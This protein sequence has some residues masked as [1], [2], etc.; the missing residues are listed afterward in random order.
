MASISFTRNRI[1][2]LGLALIF[3]V[4]IYII[5]FRVI[6]QRLERLNRRILKEVSLEKSEL[7][8]KEFD[9]FD[10]IFHLMGLAADEGQQEFMN[11]LIEQDSVKQ[12]LVAYS[13]WKSE[14][15]VYSKKL[16]WYADFLNIDSVIISNEL[17]DRHFSTHFIKSN[18]GMYVH[19]YL[20]TKSGILQVTLDLHKL[21]AYFWER[22]FGRHAYFELYDIDGVCLIYPDEKRIGQKKVTTWKRYPLK[23]STVMSDFVHM[24]VLMEEFKLQ[25][26][27]SNSK[28]FVNVLLIMTADEVRDIGNTA[29]LLGA[30]GIA[31]MLLF[32]FLIDWQ[33]GKAKQLTLRNLEY[34]K[35]DA[36]L[37][38]ENL[39][40]KVDPH[41][42]FNALG[43]L[44]QLIGKDPLQAKT[45]VGKMAKVYRKFLSRDESGLATI[46]EEVV[47]AEEYFFMQKIRF[48]D[49]LIPLEINISPEAMTLH[50]PRF[51][52]QIL[53]ENAI[54]H[55]ELNKEKP[56]SISIIETEGQLVVRN[57]VLLKNPDI[58]S[59]GYG[60]QMIAHVYDFY[61]V[62]GFEIQHNETDFIVYLPFIYIDSQ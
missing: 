7:V 8:Q 27:F 60:T 41:F 12:F 43:S 13:Y 20:T 34:Q 51:S 44:Q 2:I 18:K 33:S 15:G 50:I 29:F 16:T 48:V 30:L 40:R 5:M 32:I 45:F 42:L 26:I 24:E 21:N 37:R 9:D 11:K 10:R 59:A 61:E 54:K 28:L 38:F 4:S 31:T 58:D 17:L 56:L 23:D 39:K 49:T 55:N 19:A 3:V 36:L 52:L 14:S 57:T 25:G 35:E 47:L 62:Q 6:D 46:K 1:L 53:I 22:N